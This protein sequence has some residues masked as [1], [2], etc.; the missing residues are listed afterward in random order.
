MAIY[1][2]YNEAIAH[3]CSGLAENAKLGKGDMGGKNAF[4]LIVNV[5]RSAAS[6]QVELGMPKDNYQ[7]FYEDYL[8]GYLILAFAEVESAEALAFLV[9]SALTMPELSQAML[10]YHK[11][12]VS[13]DGAGYFDTSAEIAEFFFVFIP[14]CS[15]ISRF[16]ADLEGAQETND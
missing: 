16:W 4:E 10:G 3:I 15:G 7:P 13:S 1:D 9:D 6:L 5:A 2:T 14:L 8:V 12:H 11:R